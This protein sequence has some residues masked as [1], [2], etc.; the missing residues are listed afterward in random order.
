MENWLQHWKRQKS[1]IDCR[2]WCKSSVK[3]LYL[4][5]CNFV[6]ASDLHWF[7]WCFA[8]SQTQ[9]VFSVSRCYSQIRVYYVNWFCC[10]QRVEMR[11]LRYRYVMFF[12]YCS[13]IAANN[14]FLS[15][16]HKANSCPNWPE[17]VEIKSL[18]DS[19]GLNE[20]KNYYSVLWFQ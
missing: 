12:S 7:I 15:V 13:Q 17:S 20:S 2:K 3:F 1:S 6:W 5:I 8:C 4:S 18:C 9:S 14:C 10:S 16:G 11:S 19:S